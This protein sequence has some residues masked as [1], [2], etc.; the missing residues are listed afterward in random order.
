MTFGR[1]DYRS[2]EQARRLR[3]R[4]ILL[5]IILAT[6]PCYVVGAIMLGVAPDDDDVITEDRTLPAPAEG[7]DSL[8]SATS[9]VSP[10]PTVTSVLDAS[11]E[12]TTTLA[13]TPRQFNPP[14]STRFPTRVFFTS[15]PAPSITVNPSAT[16]TPTASPSATATN[17]PEATEPQNRAP[18]LNTPLPDVALEPGETRPVTV[19][20]DDPDNEPVSIVASSDNAGAVTIQ[21]Y[22]DN[23]FTIQAVAAG[24]A[25]I[26]VIL[27]D[28]QNAETAVTF[29][30]TVAAANQPP[31]FLQEPAPITVE[32]GTAT[33]LTLAFEDPNGDT[34]MSQVS[35]A[36][37]AIAIVGKTN[38]SQYAI[39][40]NAAGETT[41]T[42]SLNDGNGGTAQRTITVTV[43]EP[44]P[45]NRAPTIS[46]IEPSPLSL[47]NGD[48]TAVFVTANDPD[49]DNLTLSVT[50]AAPATATASRIDNQSFTVQAQAAGTTTITVTVSDGSLT[51]QQTL[52]VTVTAPNSPPSFSQE[53]PASVTLAQGA[54]R[55]ITLVYT[56][57]DN[58]AV[59]LTVSATTP[60]VVSLQK[61]NEQ[62]FTITGTNASSTQVT[63]R[64]NDGRGGT[65]TRTINVTVAVNS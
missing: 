21:A 49:G 52:S 15:T 46:A 27:S 25:T 56:D 1:D 39:S 20:A 24:S 42:I 60:N 43:N 48:S 63:I 5:F 17:S 41:A 47:T 32:V 50:S 62:A 33:A 57:P 31:T 55:Q 4:S 58:D 19:D 7:T 2:D 34:V 35:I 10:D 16:A 26:T 44:P 54:S 18:I 45:Q 65:V 36:D 14:T 59:T 28:P 64:L 51:A 12:P 11:R 29:E 22:N 23:G 9:T 3:N 6:V 38:E 40:G 30:A 37:Q 53:P 61:I 8:A 13:A